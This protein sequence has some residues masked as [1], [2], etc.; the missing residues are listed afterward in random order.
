MADEAPLE[1]TLTFEAM[2]ERE[3]CLKIAQ[4]VALDF[5]N[6]DGDR[7]YQNGVRWAAESIATK[8]GEGK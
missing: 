5:R 2:S 6:V 7:I 3:R 1:T 8:I 4:R